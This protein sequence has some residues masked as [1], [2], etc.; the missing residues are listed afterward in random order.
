MQDHINCQ[1]GFYNLQMGVSWKLLSKVGSWEPSFQKDEVMCGAQ[2]V[3]EGEAFSK[4]CQ[5]PDVSEPLK[6]LW[7]INENQRARNR[8][9]M[10][11]LA[12]ETIETPVLRLET[13]AFNEAFNTPQS[14][15]TRLVE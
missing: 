11:A 3:S 6:K 12:Q 1:F 13:G 2:P 10:A 7:T 8:V 15:R 5:S 4:L 14:N 9:H